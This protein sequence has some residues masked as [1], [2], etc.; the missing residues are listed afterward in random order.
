MD[1]KIFIAKLA[2]VFSVFVLF[3]SIFGFVSLNNSA[4]WFSNNKEVNAGGISVKMEDPNKL[5]GTLYFYDIG[6]II[7]EEEQNGQETVSY[8][9]Y[10]FKQES[11][12]KELG[13]LSVIEPTRQLL[14]RLDLKEG[15][16]S[17]VITGETSLTDYPSE[18]T[19]AENPASTVV[20]FQV[21]T[22]VVM[23]ELTEEEWNALSDA[24]KADGNKNGYVISS[25][26]LGTATHFATINED[27]KTFAFESSIDIYET[28]DNASV[29][30]VFILVDYYE[31]STEYILNLANNSKIN[32]ITV[33][34][35]NI[36]FT[37]D[38]SLIIA[39]K[40]TPVV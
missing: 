21:L 2:T 11:A 4:A 33:G 31:P 10:V 5:V 16:D 9:K 38:F 6:T 22:D 26:D 32:G 37:S 34:V 17:V 23:Q 35:D 14:I 12:K 29:N 24:H 19:P 18:F 27:K 25:Q 40:E 3:L 8:N 28:P 30:S 13:L 39:K 20:Q 36:G 1:K 7:L 15:V